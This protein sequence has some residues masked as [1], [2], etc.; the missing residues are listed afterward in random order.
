M[1]S[2]L[3]LNY[4]LEGKWNA[5]FV[6]T[7]YCIVNMLT[8]LKAKAVNKYYHLNSVFMTFS[9]LFFFRSLGSH[10]FFLSANFLGRAGRKAFVG[11]TS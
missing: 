9:N 11:Q 2:F 4:E 8:P 1:T 7:A 10:F 3:T 5:P 6:L